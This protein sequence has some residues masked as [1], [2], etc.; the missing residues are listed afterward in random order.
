MSPVTEERK[1]TM[2]KGQQCRKCLP[3][4]SSRL[5]GADVPLRVP[6]ARGEVRYSITSMPVAPVI[7]RRRA[8]CKYMIVT[9]WSKR[10]VVVVVLNFREQ[11]QR[12]CSFVTRLSALSE[13]KR[14]RVGARVLEFA[15]FGARRPVTPPVTCVA[16]YITGMVMGTWCRLSP[17]AMSLTSSLLTSHF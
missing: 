3:A 15:P 4:A 7:Q 12:C 16:D 13:D 6:S 1:P 5:A 14:C 2:I 17:F 9:L 10:A 11:V 8:P